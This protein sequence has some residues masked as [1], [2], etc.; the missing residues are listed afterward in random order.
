MSNKNWFLEKVPPCDKIMFQIKLFFL[1]S[2]DPVLGRSIGFWDT[3]HNL[4][5]FYDLGY[6]MK[7][8]KNKHDCLFMFNPTEEPF[9]PDEEGN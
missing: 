8:P 9:P 2:I 4:A 7:N 6:C 1:F 5:F 3:S